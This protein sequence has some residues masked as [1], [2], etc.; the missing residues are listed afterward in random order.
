M[1]RYIA[2]LRGINVSDQKLIK[3]EMLRK[4]LTDAGFVDVKTYIQSGNI[5][6]SSD[7]NDEN[8]LIQKTEDLIELNFGFRTD[9][10]I[11]KRKQIEAIV[12]SPYFIPMKSDEEKKFY[13]T[14]LKHKNS[15]L[16]EFPYF[17]KNGDIELLQGNEWEIYSVCTMYKGVYGFSNAF[18]EKLTGMPATTRNPLT[19]QKIL[20]I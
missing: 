18:V 7:E 4:V 9:V 6:F 20:A 19:L 1:E 5:L 15:K 13:I 2:F 12:N 11:R 10:I 14:F 17:S 16:T 8:Q 3:M